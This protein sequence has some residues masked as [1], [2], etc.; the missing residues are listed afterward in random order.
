RSNALN[1]CF[2]IV[3]KS[4]AVDRI[5]FFQNNIQEQTISLQLEWTQHNSQITDPELQN[6]SFCQIPIIR[7]ALENGKPFAAFVSSLPP[8][9]I[10]DVLLKQNVISL[11]ILPVMVNDQ[12]FGFLRLDDCQAA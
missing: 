2:Q 8:S 3:G 5:F 7:E 11:L 12:F 9:S 6:I 1:Q 4:L 10:K